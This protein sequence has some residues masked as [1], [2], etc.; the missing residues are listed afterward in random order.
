MAAKNAAPDTE[1]DLS[2]HPAD[3]SRARTL[4]PEQVEHFNDRGYIMPLDALDDAEADAQRDYFD[5]LMEETARRGGNSYSINGYHTRCRGL[6]DLCVTPRI[7]DYVQDI[8]GPNFLVW[9]THYFCKTPHDPKAVPWHQDAS[10]WPLTPSRTVTVWLAIDDVDVHNSAMR[11][12]AGTHRMG[13]LAFKQT[14]QQA[15]LGQEV[16]DAETLGDIVDVEL[17][18]GQISLH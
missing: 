16:L 15:V 7:L 4:T 5:M 12:I 8:L 9:G 11:F 17:K 10:Y 6:Y 13:H 1:R 14:E 3:P 2:F 18:A